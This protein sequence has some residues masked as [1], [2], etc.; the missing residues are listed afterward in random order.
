MIRDPSPYRY[1]SAVVISFA[2]W[3]WSIAIMVS[4][5][6]EPVFLVL[7]VPPGYC[8]LAALLRN[9]ILLT[10]ARYVAY[11]FLVASAKAFTRP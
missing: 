8:L 7:V 5:D 1:W 11:F 10:I 4:C 9:R 2:S 3:L 6:G